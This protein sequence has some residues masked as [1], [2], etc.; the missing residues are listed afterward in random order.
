MNNQ[1]PRI[2]ILTAS[3]GEG[4]LQASNALKQRFLAHG[5]EEVHIVDLMK[6]AHPL[7]NTISMKLYIKSTQTPKYGLDYYGWSYYMTRDTKPE[8]SWNKYFNLLGKKK[9]KEMIQ[10]LRPD[11]V[12]N[13]FPFGAA[14]EIGREAS[15]PTFTVVTDYALHSRWIHPDNEKYYVATQEL[16]QELLAK[17]LDDDQVQISGI[18]I[19]QAFTN[20]S[21]AKNRFLDRIDPNKKTVLILAGSYGVLNH[22]EDM[23]NALR[24]RGDCE[25]AI[26]CGRNRKLENKLSEMF[27]TDSNVRIF[28]FVEH[29][30]EL[31]ALSSCVVTK[32][33]GLTLTEALALRLPIFIYKPLAG[34]EKENAVYFENKGMAKISNTTAELEQQIVQFLSDSSMPQQMKACMESVQKADAAE[35]IVQDV[36]KTVEHRLSVTV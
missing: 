33:G 14:P 34:Q 9:L 31:M 25:L 19:R 18:P 12:I 5:I 16:K 21:G 6:E 28:G 15:I 27:A 35:F 29:I 13:T 32:A 24:K 1:H 30:H 3:Y 8:G 2:M 22:I 11:A 20:V 4:H 17:G 23:A 26:V 36:L 10:E 7:L